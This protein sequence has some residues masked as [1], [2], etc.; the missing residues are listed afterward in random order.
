MLTKLTGD[1]LIIIS[2]SQP[3]LSP[4]EKYIWKT[5]KQTNSKK[6]TYTWEAKLRTES[7][8]E[9]ELVFSSYT[10]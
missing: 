7:L 8:N 6:E 5:N 3:I 10:P 1:K 2:L 9:Q 4:L